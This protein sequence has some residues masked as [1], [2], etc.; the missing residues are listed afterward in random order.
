[1]LRFDQLEKKFY[2]NTERKEKGRLTKWDRKGHSFERMS[3]LS[4]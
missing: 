2:E 4:F 1:M 3:S